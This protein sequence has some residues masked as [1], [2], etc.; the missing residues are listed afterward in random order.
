[1]T[2]DLTAAA[3]DS[4]QALVELTVAVAA[5]SKR[6]EK[7]A[8]LAA[9]FSQ[10]DD[11]QL[12]LA[13]RFVAG[14]PFPLWDARSIQVGPAAALA[15]IAACCGQEVASLRPELVR[16]G[17]LGDLAAATWPPA[18]GPTDGPSLS[19][20]EAGLVALAVSRGGAPRRQQLIALLQPLDG[21]QARLLIKLAMGELR[22]GLQEGAVEAAIAA[23]A[24]VP[25]GQVQWA[26]MLL[27]DLGETA[28]RARRGEL[29]SL[30]MRLFHPLKF[31]LASPV[32]DAAAAVAA[33]DGAP[34]IVEDKYDGIRAQVHLGPVGGDASVPEAVRGVVH[35]QV[36]I[37]L[38]TRSLADITESFADLWPGL[39][40]LVQAPGGPHTLVLDGEILPVDGG[41]ILP[42]SA[43]QPR[44]GRRSPTALAQPVAFM[45]F[46]LLAVDDVICLL[47]PH[48]ERRRRLEAAVP[49]GGGEV[50]GPVRRA[51][52]LVVD[53]L[54]D[55]DARFDAARARGNEGLMLKDPTA[56]YRPGRRGRDWL[57]LKKPVGTLDVV[58]TAAEVGHGRRR[59][60][61]S[62]LTF[63]VRRSADDPTLLGLGKAYSGLTD[64]EIAELTLW[65][66]EHTHT[67]LAHGRVCLVEP[68][69]V[70]EVAFDRVQISP[71]H[72][73]GY[74]LRFPRIL[75]LRPDKSVADIDTL[76][77][78]EALV[79]PPKT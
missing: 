21:G 58:V 46:D 50:D 8:L 26:N 29:E 45:A 25:V 74:A 2:Q 4:L 20:V 40:A 70:L 7:S 57:K 69:I 59:E 39:A 30:R 54:S 18:S 51:P 41:D 17:D 33:A 9:Y 15:A 48:T 65:F 10:L 34:R 16:L 36:R 47:E 14:Q 73:S 55:L 72:K 67:R 28:V 78:V 49:E 6:S 37:A 61:L 44:L 75:R 68:K 42:F 63:A 71:R 52:S 13:A 5:T 3:P 56:A 23:A 27:G 22:I 60:W 79:E 35:G 24:E 32:V 64:A 77:A 38:F 1:M 12:R 19:D 11:A 66:R 31:M 43:L 62:D 76:A 53:G